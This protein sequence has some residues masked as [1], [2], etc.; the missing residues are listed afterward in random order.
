M[1]KVS[2]K[3]SF[4][5]T[6]ALMGV[7]RDGTLIDSENDETVERNLEIQFASSDLRSFVVI[8]WL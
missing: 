6:I 4:T 3:T 2:R 8:F 7:R 1:Q 5:S